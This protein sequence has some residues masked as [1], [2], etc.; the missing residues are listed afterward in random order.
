MNK[1]VGV[2][3]L[4]SVC[5]LDCPDTCSLKVEVSDGEIVSIKGGTANPYT[6]GVICN[7]VTRAYPEFVHGERRL[8]YPM[9][10]TG[11][12][13]SGSF[14]RISWD[15]ALDLVYEGFSKALDAH[16]GQ[17]ILPFN[18]AGPHGELTTGSMD[19]RFFY[20]LGA[21]Q[22][23]RGPLCGGVRGLAYSSLFG[24]VAGMAPQQAVDA[25]LIV[26]WGS[27][28]TVSYLHQMRVFNAARKKG[29]KLVVIDPKRTKIAQQCDLFIQIEPG[30]DVV[31][32]YAL[33]AEIERR[34]GLDKDFIAR[35]VV[36]A[37]E[38]ME[39][40][41][42]YGVDDVE[43]ICGIDADD[44]AT[45]AKM[46]VE[47]GNVAAAFGNGIERGRSGGSGLRAAMGLQALTGNFGRRGAGV[48]AKAGLAAPKTQARL[49][50]SDLIK[51]GTRTFNILDIPAKIMDENLDPPIMATMIFNHNPVA[52]HPNQSGM[53]KALMR[54]DLFVAGCD[55]VMT[56][57]MALCD[58]LLPA[59]SHFET[60]DIYGAY[61]QN[62][63]QRA[64]PVI[65]PVGESLPNTE[66]FRRLAARF[67][68]DEPMF[69][70]SDQQL[71][72]EAMDGS[73]P[74]FGGLKPSELPLDGALAM[75]AD[76]GDDLM[77]CANH[78][79]K[80]PS[81]KIE[82][83][84]VDLEARYG[85]GLPRFDPVR[86]DRPFA[87]ISPSS[88][89]RTNAT[90]GGCSLSDGHE[91]VEM[92]PQDADA[93]GLED[94]EIVRLFNDLGEV[95]LQL[96][97]SDATRPGVLYVPKGAWR[98]TSE[99]GQTTNALI[100]VDVRTDIGDG[101]CYHETFVDVEVAKLS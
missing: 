66:I 34:G 95:N 9:K 73:D 2:Q 60:S 98:R 15:E 76:N 58:V 57:S 45:L 69:T 37:D 65:P 84:S 47:A 86:R 53:I 5:P 46:Y 93:K 39:A 18:Y 90:F 3:T 30:T 43:A 101:A 77:L 82:L 26:V 67:G 27:N 13:G 61:G 92:H 14:E 54:E 96:K 11:A 97:V 79:P 99:T 36:G 12:R 75:K 55:V 49:H 83:Y 48:L 29:A 89:K 20:T 8:K 63:V 70:A 87:V 78:S 1:H 64:E 100:P 19:R 88:D 17:S 59:S 6:Q 71:M 62:F 72:D 24:D 56:D 23:D 28:I 52:V 25:D 42:P 44:F 38:F 16:G 40:A 41:R 33:A 94:G 10:R 51:P 68:F 4:P 32:A 91:V 21:T 35:W 7:K 85:F 74:R 50:R 80:T 31:F 81:G 22:L